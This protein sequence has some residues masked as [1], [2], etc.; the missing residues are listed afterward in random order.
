MS[1]RHEG[2]LARLSAEAVRALINTPESGWI[3]LPPGPAEWVVRLELLHV[4]GGPL[5]QAANGG[6]S[7]AVKLTVRGE[8]VR[9]YAMIKA[10]EDLG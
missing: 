10:L 8:V 5:V 3:A 1:Q 2:I 4:E 6:A 7:T 9:H